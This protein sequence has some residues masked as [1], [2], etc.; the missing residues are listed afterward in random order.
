M[1]IPSRTVIRESLCELD[2]TLDEPLYRSVH[3]LGPDME[4]PEQVQ[5][6]LGQDSHEK[7]GLV[8]GEAVETG[9]V[10]AQRV[11]LLFDPIINVATSV[12]YLDRLPSTDPGI[13]CNESQS[14]ERVPHCAT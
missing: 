10:P 6:V 7:L 9:L 3:L 4:E 12:I 5:E 2:E 8:G 1:N 13:N 11:L 14:W